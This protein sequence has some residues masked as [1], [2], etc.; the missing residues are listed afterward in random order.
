LTFDLEALLRTLKP[1][2]SAG[3]LSRRA[4]GALR[5]VTADTTDNI[6]DLDL[7]QQLAPIGKG[8]VLFY[9]EL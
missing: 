4:D 6:A 7:I 8:R 1:V 5:F 2:K 9:R 3:R